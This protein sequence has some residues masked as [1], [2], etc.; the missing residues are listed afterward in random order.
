M[1]ISEKL[2][3]KKKKGSEIMNLEDALKE[4]NIMTNTSDSKKRQACNC[5]GELIN[6]LSC[7][8]HTMGHQ[9]LINT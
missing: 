7:L 1:L 5:Q 6:M 9:K 2:A 3:P 8:H 4:L